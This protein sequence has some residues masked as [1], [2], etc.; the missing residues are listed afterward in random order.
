MADWPTDFTRGDFFVD[1]LS[2]WGE[3]G[4]NALDGAGLTSTA[5]P[6]ANDALFVPIAVPVPVTVYQMACGTGTGTTGN[7]DLGIY[8]V[9]G[10]L[11]VSTGS[12]AKTTANVERVVNVT[13][14]VLL[15]GLYYLAMSV[16]DTGAYQAPASIGNVGFVKLLGMRLV[17]TAFALPSTVTLATVTSTVIPCI[18]AYLRSD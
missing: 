10:N 14:T 18:S 1:S 9:G 2:V 12:T 13:D 6:N 15:P 11:L 8:D 16:D 5:W 4:P 17:S 7:F 3:V